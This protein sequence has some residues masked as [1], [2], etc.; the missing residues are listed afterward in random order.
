M[1]RL[2]RLLSIVMAVGAVASPGAEAT[3]TVD[4]T[5]IAD[6]D[7]ACEG[8]TGYRFDYSLFG[9][10]K[11]LPKQ[12]FDDGAWTY[13][14]M[15]DGVVPRRATLRTPTGDVVVTPYP[16]AP[17]YVL[18]G[19][20]DQIE[21]EVGKNKVIAERKA[22]RREAERRRKEEEE[23]R[24]RTQLEEEQAWLQAQV[25]KLNEELRTAKDTIATLAEV[26]AAALRAE[27]ERLAVE[28]A[29]RDA[30][31]VAFQVREGS[32]KANVT[33]IVQEAGWTRAV[34][35]AEQDDYPVPGSFT[36]AGKDLAEA[37]NKLLKDYPVRAELYEVNKVAVIIGR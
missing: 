3:E 6:T 29:K 26:Q 31:K 21:I 17:Y 13:V 37:L 30:E 23:K 35:K 12:V 10:A 2:L 1:K 15:P 25:E 11:S 7:P 24:R 4:C 36:I 8:R 34:W 9:E 5:G 14:Q 16:S 33:R 18:R 32:L 19:T 27:E 20:A 22:D 28:L